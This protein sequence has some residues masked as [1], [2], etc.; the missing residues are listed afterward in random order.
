MNHLDLDAILDECVGRIR[1]GATLEDCL[2][3]YPTKRGELATLLTLSAHLL[4]LPE[5]SA[6]SEATVAGKDKML[7]AATAV[8]ASPAAPPTHLPFIAWKQRLTRSLNKERITMQLIWRATAL[9]LLVFIIGSGFAIGASAQ[10]LPGEALYPVKRA[11]EGTQLTLTFDPQARQDLETQFQTQRYQEIQRLIAAGQP[12]LVEFE[13]VLETISPGEWL[14]NG[15]KLQINANTAV[16]GSPAVGRLLQIK[17]RVLSTG[18][19]LAMAIHVNDDVVTVSWP[20]YPPTQTPTN[21]P[22]IT[23]TVHPT[24]TPRVTPPG[25]PS[26]TPPN[27]PSPTPPCSPSHCTTPTPPITPTCVPGANCDPHTPTPHSTVT[28]PCD[29]VRCGTHTPLPPTVTA[30]PPHEPSPTPPNCQPG[31]CPTP[32]PHA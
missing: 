11:W 30:T 28:P 23:P 15:I 21:Q 25:E 6:S 27:E 32:T 9:A 17:A 3:D 1:Q 26:S 2:A 10:S 7:A 29:P 24:K 16:T 18:K 22:Q 12:A 4:A 19:L 13:G 8:F 31:A 5:L 14:V 20:A